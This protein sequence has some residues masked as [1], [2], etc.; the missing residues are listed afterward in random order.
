MLSPPGEASSY[1]EPLEPADVPLDAVVER[2]RRRIAGLERHYEARTGEVDALR[3]RL[4]EQE[5]RA[6]AATAELAALRAEHE[7]LMHTLTMRLLR[8][9]REWYGDLR[10]RL[11]RS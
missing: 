4:A 5:A 8:R 6:A 7:A 10:R 1:G 11:G 9:P 3:A 2:L